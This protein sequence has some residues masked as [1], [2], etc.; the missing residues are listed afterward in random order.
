MIDRDKIKYVLDN[1]LTKDYNY[2]LAHQI[3]DYF[4]VQA[5]SLE[6]YNVLGELSIKA[7]HDGLRLK[8][9]EYVYTHCKTTEE[10]YAARENLIQIYNTLNQPEKALFYVDLNLM[11]KPNDF[12]MLQYKAF[13][14]ALMN[15]REESEKILLSLIAT[16]N[17]QKENLD[18][19]LSGRQLRSGDTANG[20]KNF[21]TKFKPLN[22]LFQDQLKLK[23][24][25]G[26]VYPGKTI[27]VN[28]EGGIGDEIINIRF[29]KWFERM[30]M[31]PILYS[32]WSKFRPDIVDVF[33]RHGYRVETNFLFFQKDWLWTHMMALPAYMGLQ[34]KDLWTGPYLNPLRQ[35]KN[36]LDDSNFK[37]GI[38][39]SG[40]PY[41]DQDVYRKI[42]VDQMLSI[43][44]KE[45]SVY[46]VDK[47]KS[48][49]DCIGLKDRIDTWEDTLDFIDQMDIVVSSCT[50]LV[51]AAGA[52]G[53]RTIV[54]VPIAEY[55]VWTST[56]TNN[57]TPWY[58]DNLTVL[59]Q[60]KLRS[61]QE[62]LDKAKDLIIKEM[63]NRL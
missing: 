6:D 62:P 8:A 43:M 22:P 24:W 44:P 50:S 38:K 13:N 19:V 7:K 30:G 28:G 25:D 33:R 51:H 41:F 1:I 32:S 20:I 49:D 63:S 10:L 54:V 34:E 53:K 16:T 27:V 18:Y 26:G 9:A 15:R 11:I 60:T 23:F 46:Y 55:Y 61:W 57:T 17:K 47:E 29:F 59:K 42:P 14:L 56:R 5:T 39:C 45:A 4:E 21:I 3:L 40:N 12:D 37:I 31:T 58:G 36:Q 35:E 48:P 52:M 2:P